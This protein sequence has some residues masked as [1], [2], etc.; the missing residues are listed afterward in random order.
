MKPTREEIVKWLRDTASPPSDPPVNDT[1]AQMQRAAADLLDADEVFLDRIVD[2]EKERNIPAETEEDNTRVCSECHLEYEREKPTCPRCGW[3]PNA[4]PLGACAAPSPRE[5]H[6]GLCDAPIDYT[7]AAN[8]NDAW[9]RVGR[10][11]DPAELQQWAYRVMAALRAAQWR[12]R[13]AVQL[14]LRREPEGHYTLLLECLGTPRH[15][16]GLVHLTSDKEPDK[17]DLTCLA[18]YYASTIGA[19]VFKAWQQRVA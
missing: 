8:E 19:A 2:R 14:S 6:S 13:N 4:N 16:L 15:A 11:T 10:T 12:A 7:L 17:N 1:R 18:Q 9:E 3:E 5:P